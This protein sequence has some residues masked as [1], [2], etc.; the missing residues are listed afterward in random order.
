MVKLLL[1][2]CNK[3]ED[4]SL[5]GGPLDNDFSLSKKLYP[6]QYK[7]LVNAYKI[8]K[9]YYTDIQGNKQIFYQ[10]VYKG[11]VKEYLELKIKESRIRTYLSLTED[12]KIHFFEIVN[13][14]GFWMG[15]GS[16]KTLVIVKLSR[17]LKRLMND[18]EIPGK[19]ILFLTARDDLIEQFKR[20]VEEYNQSNSLNIELV[21][22][23]EFEFEKIKANSEIEFPNR[24]RVFYYRSD[25]ITDKSGEKRIDF[26]TVY[27][28]GNWYLILD[29][30]HKGDKTES[31]YQAIFTVLTKNGFMFNF[32]ATFT[33]EIDFWTCTY[34]YNLSTFTEKGYGKHIYL[35]ARGVEG[36][37]KK[38]DFPEEVKS[39]TVL[40]RFYF[41]LPCV[42]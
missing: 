22:L 26:E 10:K 21:E 39:K 34:K 31:K 40:R 35:S 23:S 11:V 28:D 36:F 42:R 20:H 4:F 30:A 12:G 19:D 9:L 25:L 8:F 1:M 13:R 27:N 41:I 7:A 14:A 17:L 33:E 24:V 32:S 2:L 16:G 37:N 38:E 5:N 18:R 29:E 3:I 15:T 6:Y